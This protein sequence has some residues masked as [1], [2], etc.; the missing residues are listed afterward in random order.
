MGLELT[1]AIGIDK[2][3]NEQHG[4]SGSPHKRSKDIAYSQKHRV[5]LGSSHNIATQMYA[6]RNDK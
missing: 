6:P 2:R 5:G 1:L 4:S 3:A